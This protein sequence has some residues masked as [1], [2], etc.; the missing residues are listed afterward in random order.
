MP[1]EAAPTGAKNTETSRRMERRPVL[2]VASAQRAASGPPNDETSKQRRQRLIKERVIEE[3]SCSPQRLAELF[4]VSLMT[5]HRDL[6][7]LEQRGLVRKFHGGVTAQPSGVFESLLSYRMTTRVEEKQRIADCA[8]K[9]VAPG[10]SLILDDSTTA[11]QMIPGL[12][13]LTPLHV[14]TPFLPALHQLAEIA[15]ERDLTILGLGGTYD[16]RHESFV[17]MR[18]IEQVEAIRAEAVFMSLSAVSGL[19]TFHQEEGIVALKQA[20]IGA[21]AHR[22]LLVDSGKFGTAALYRAIPLEGFDLVITDA[23]ADPEVLAEWRAN[24]I[25]F[26]VAS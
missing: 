9:Y 6:D 5:I 23:D 24:G 25:A 7:A 3:G 4:K 10:M 21:A 19:H 22:Y 14:A 11:L 20:M 2:D 18:C 26:E 15:A 16:L 12:A 13:E 17:G 8:L 1:R